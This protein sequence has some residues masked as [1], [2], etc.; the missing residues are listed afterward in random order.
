ME[1]S[2]KNMNEF[3]QTNMEAIISV[4]LILTFLLLLFNLFLFFKYRKIKKLS[5]DFFSGKNG[6]DLERVIQVQKKQIIKL[7]ENIKELF[8]GY[9]KIYKIALKGL[10]KVGIVRYNPFND[11]GG[12][13]SFVIAL[14]DGGKSGLII[15]SLHTREGT[16]IFSKTIFNGK[17]LSGQLTEEEQRAV[18]IARASKKNAIV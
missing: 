1:K 6:K 13:Q 10:Q 12:N 11:I 9:E 17:A 18:K 14:L 7:E 8:D 3:L 15:T 16:R 4:C 2:N 5:N